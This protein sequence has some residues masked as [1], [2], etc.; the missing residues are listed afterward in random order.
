MKSSNE[1]LKARG[2]CET[3]ME[4]FCAGLGFHEKI[5]LLKSKV[6]FERTLGARLLIKEGKQSIPFLITALLTE[7]KLYPKIEICNTLSRLGKPAVKPLID[8]LGKIGTNQHKDLPEKQFRKKSYPLPRDI[9]ARTLAHMGDTALP[10]LTEALST[11]DTALLSEAID[12]T[13]YICFYNDHPQVLNKLRECYDT[14]NTN[15]LIRWK[16]IRAMSAFTESYNTLTQL[17]Q[18]EKNSSIAQEISRSLS[19]LRDKKNNR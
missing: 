5:M 1:I 3:G 14:H 15:D 12:A 16:I 8:L 18:A 11:H 19:L 6:P 9:A 7:K 4:F 10:E 17:L 13:G 2:F